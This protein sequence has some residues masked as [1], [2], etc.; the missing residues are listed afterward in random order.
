M[1][2]SEHDDGRLTVNEIFNIKLNARL[3]TLSACETGLGELSRGDDLI[4]LSRAFIYSGT[5][6]VVVSLWKV[7]DATTS[8]LMKRFN[9]YLSSGK[10]A[11]ESLA[12]AQRDMINGAALEGN[13]AENISSDELLSNV[14]SSGNDDNVRN[15]YFWGPFTLIGH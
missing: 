3:V 6:A 9:G 13:K 14:R 10:G 11:A 5:P 1:H 2:P 8:V 4:G 7:D 15:P 12:F